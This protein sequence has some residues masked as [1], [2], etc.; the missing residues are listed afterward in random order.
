MW[1]RSERPKKGLGILPGESSQGREL[2]RVSH[3]FKI[4]EWSSYSAPV[5]LVIE[6]RPWLNFRLDRAVKTVGFSPAG[7]RPPAVLRVFLK[8]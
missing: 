4:L 8:C 5:G 2:K 6:A 3:S 1:E 7:G